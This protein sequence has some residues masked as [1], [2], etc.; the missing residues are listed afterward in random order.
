MIGAVVLLATFLL[1]WTHHSEEDAHYTP[2]Y[3]MENITEYLEQEQLDEEEYAILYRQTGLSRIAIDTLQEQ[4]RNVEILAAQKRF[5]EEVE[6]SCEGNLILYSEVLERPK[7]SLYTT[8]N[9]RTVMRGSSRE[10]NAAIIP[11]LE[12]GDILITFNSHFL[13]WRNG[14]AAIV[15]D[16]EKG[17]TLEALTLGKNSAIL[18]VRSWSEKP[19]FAVL[20]LRGTTK[21]QRAEIA[22]YA[23]ETLADVPYRLTAGLWETEDSAAEIPGT[24]CAHLI[25]SAYKQFGYD[26]DSD[27]GRIVTPRDLYDSP[28]LEKIQIYGL[29]PG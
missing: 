25:W 8:S 17:R 3:P 26:L 28:M 16:A 7:E 13:G 20:R 11:V 1:F 12:D 23:E 27:G 14:H 22:K 10:K 9:A 6:V 21:K 29:K 4:G 24:H 5:F 2:D 15:I 19:S 18:S